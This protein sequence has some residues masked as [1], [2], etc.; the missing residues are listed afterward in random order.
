[1]LRSIGKSFAHIV[2]KPATLPH[3]DRRLGCPG[4]SEARPA[5]SKKTG[6]SAVRQVDRTRVPF[7]LLIFCCLLLIFLLLISC[8]FVANLLLLIPVIFAY[9]QATPAL[10]KSLP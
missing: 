5:C 8:C 6:A 7:R 3:R 9:A 10:Q 4:P 1:M 2:R